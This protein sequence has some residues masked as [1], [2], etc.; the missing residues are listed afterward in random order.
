MRIAFL[1]RH[2]VLDSTLVASPPRLNRRRGLEVGMKRAWRFVVL[3]LAA[4]ALGCAARS[5]PAQ[6]QQQ[7][8]RQAPQTAQPA[9]EQQQVRS[10]ERFI[11]VTGQ[12]LPGACYHDLGSLQFTEPFTDAAID[13][14]NSRAADRLRVLALQ[15]YPN[16]VDAVIGVRSQEND[17]GTLVTISGEA[18]ELRKGE[19][20]ECAMRKVPG[21]LDTAATSAAGGMVGTLVGGLTMGSTVGAMGGAGAGVAI[22]SGYQAIK[23]HQADAAQ[24]DQLVAQLEAQR[25]EIS[26]LQAERAQLEQC[27][28]R[29]TP[30][31]QCKP[32]AVPTGANA[33]DARAAEAADWSAPPYELQRQIQE[34]QIYIKK[35]REQI[36]DARRQ[37][38]GH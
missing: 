22:S 17:V 34:Q 18:V 14:D 1:T 36:S 16:D 8:A 15:H 12:G 28:A 11:Y 13:P 26:E 37:L 25:R 30:L 19:T 38:S 2:V 6:S 21:A 4:A 3:A 23:K 31:A 33:T 27:A 35:L 5:T 20:V 7:Q 29:E 10:A 24:H 32:A 9:Q